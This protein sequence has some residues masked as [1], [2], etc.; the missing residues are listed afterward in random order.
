[1]I[2]A[3]NREVHI[4]SSL[5]Y[6]KHPNI[7]NLITAFEKGRT[8]NFL[9]PLA[10]GDL[11]N[12]LGSSSGLT[13]FQT[14]DEIVASLWGLSSALEKVHEFCVKELNIEQVGCHYDIKP[15][16]ILCLEG[17]LVLSDFGLSRLRPVEKGSR[18]Y[19]K[20]G[21]GSYLAPE[22]EPSDNDYEPGKI[23]RASDVWS[24][25]CVLAEVL[26]YMSGGTNG[27]PDEVERFYEVRKIKL[28]NMICHHFH[29]TDKINPKVAE[30]LDDHISKSP[31]SLKSLA[32]IIKDMLQFEAD[33]RIPTPLITLRLFQLS[34]RS[35]V[36][37]LRTALDEHT[38]SMDFEQEIVLERLNI[39]AQVTGLDFG[40]P[41]NLKSAWFATPHSLEEYLRLE[42]I[43]GQCVTEIG[44][45]VARIGKIGKEPYH[46]FGH[47]KRLLDELW[48][49]QS[50]SVRAEMIRRLEDEILKKWQKAGSRELGI[51]M[52]RDESSLELEKETNGS[53]RLDYRRMENLF[54]MKE[55]ASA[56]KEEESGQSLWI[57]ESSLIRRKNLD[58]H[59][60]TFTLQDT[61]KRVLVENLEYGHS[62]IGRESELIER[63][64]SIASLRSQDVI[65][66]TFPVLQC[67]GYYN[68]NSNRSFG[69]VYS[70]PHLARGED[71][72]NLTQIFG[73]TK[74]RIQQPSLT[75]KFK[76]ASSLV[77][78][79]L[80]FHRGDWLH[81]NVSSFNI[82]CFPTAFPTIAESLSSPFFIGFNHSRHN[83]E[84]NYSSL[85]GPEAEYRHPAYL[86][87]QRSFSGQPAQ[88]FRQE[89]DYYS[90]GMVLIELAFWKPIG[91]ITKNV[92]GSPE[93]MRKHLL[94][95]E[96]RRVRTCMGDAY[97]KSVNY[98]LD[99]YSGDD[100]D[101]EQVRND[102][103]DKV[104]TV[105]SQ[106]IV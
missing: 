77:S 36:K 97:A 85:D 64:K 66:E 80:N 12:L 82:I 96:M 84:R 10:S 105:I 29:G 6:L 54:T 34:Q 53:I 43:L 91:E 99:C 101:D 21:E 13:G 14:Q 7:I 35:T 106:C 37:K 23:G 57:Q 32:Y 25:G 51:D 5:R 93:E 94:Q 41:D 8:C 68:D 11:E 28:G 95:E 2:D 27:N 59:T 16:N 67:I 3:F 20:K 79:I 39:W 50:S 69:V 30:F 78:H 88:R 56:M 98:C 18:S 73:K 102:F 74:S 33:H 86:Q 15:R 75:Q 38:D 45:I 65:K 40:P 72:V 52:G 60:Q 71:P 103:N 44:F 58:D 92:I 26:A 19:F 89:F 55:I 70:L 83:D 47:L 22:C 31:E 104:V 9:F 17:K 81:K 62:W 24:L 90:V 49:T 63:V 76:L 46:T 100:R 48:D 4:L 1:M 61:E 87:N 42:G